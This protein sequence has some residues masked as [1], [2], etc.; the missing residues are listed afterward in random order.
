MDADVFALG[1]EILS[2]L[3]HFRSYD[4]LAFALSIL[5]ERNNAIDFADDGELLGLACFEELCNPR[6]SSRNAFGLGR[7]WG[8]LGKNV[9]RVNRLPALQ[10]SMSPHGQGI[11]SSYHTGKPRGLSPNM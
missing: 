5:A 11:T 7:L 2:R 1:D 6:K 8:V 3:S 10:F 4:D 9:A